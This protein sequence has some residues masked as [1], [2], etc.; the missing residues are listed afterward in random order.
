MKHIILILLCAALL[1]SIPGVNA[2]EDRPPTIFRFESD[3]TSVTVAQLEAGDQRVT[4][5]WHVAHIT[6]EHRLSLHVYQGYEW[7]LINTLL[8]P[9][10]GQQIKLEHSRNFTPPTF[11]LSIVDRAENILDERALV[12]PYDQ[13]ALAGKTPIIESFT[14]TTPSIDAA[15]VAAGNI[16]VPV[17]WQVLDRLPLTNLVFEQVLGENQARNAELPREILWVPSS[18]TGVVAAVPPPNSSQI[19]LRLRV[20]DVITADV[21]A[22]A[23]IM[24][25]IIGTALPPDPGTSPTATPNMDTPPVAGDLN[26]LTDC[27]ASPA[28]NPPRGWQDGPGIPSPDNQFYIYAANPTGDAKLMIVRADGSG[29]T[30]LDAPDK[31]LPLA[32][33][34]RW[35]PDGQ[36]IV[37]ANIAISQPGGGTIYVVKADG[38]DLRRVTQYTGYYDALA[39][40]P[41]GSRLY[42]TSGEVS[43]TGSG[44]TVINYQVYAVTADGFGTPQALV[45]G[46]GVR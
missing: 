15:T 44:M 4:L 19:A 1:V 34:P 10:G 16:R 39:W 18:G 17:T 29:Q 14:T 25:P 32:T 46:C 38:T 8:P 31:A 22:E 13:A 2:Q 3:L 30:I 33:Q 35:S 5:T 28:G 37:F 11:R 23:L 36:W 26:L 12:I 41:D 42:F 27:P 43:G 24:V 6:D 9:V 21:Y 40:S 45:D 7:V 20:V